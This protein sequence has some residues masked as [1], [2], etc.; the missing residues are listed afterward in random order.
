[1][2]LG[3]STVMALVVYPEGFLESFWSSVCAESLKFIL[4]S[5]REHGSSNSRVDELASKSE[6]KQAKI[7]AFLL[8]CSLSRLPPEDAT[9]I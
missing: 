6:D 4:I 3:I 1:M 9:N 7:Q 2:R 5:A 8:P